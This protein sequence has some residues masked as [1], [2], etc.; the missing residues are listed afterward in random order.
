M[1]DSRRDFIKKAATA[2]AAVSIGGIL[3]AF[4]PKSYGRILGANDRIKVGIMGVHARG[5]ALAKNY[6]Q[7]NNCEV[8]SISDV[9]TN[10][11]DK[12]VG[13]VNGIQNSKPKAIGDFRKA[14]ELKEMDAMVIATPD[15]WPADRKS[16]V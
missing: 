5:L 6:A 7:Q 4:T 11:M 3:P 2:T 10:Y 8:I 14:L 1:K 15:H 9:V 16:V 12:C 13:I